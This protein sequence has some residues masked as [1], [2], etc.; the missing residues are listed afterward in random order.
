[1]KVGDLARTRDGWEPTNPAYLSL[2]EADELGIVVEVDERSR[3]GYNAGNR[4][5]E[6]VDVKVRWFPKG[7]AGEETWICSSHLEVI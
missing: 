1:M 5:I 2:A 6:L 3:G 7:L 4:I